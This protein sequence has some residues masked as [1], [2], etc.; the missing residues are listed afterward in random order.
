MTHDEDLEED[1]IL[2]D[3]VE[4]LDIN[5]EG[6]DTESY[7]ELDFEKVDL[8]NSQVDDFYEMREKPTEN[9]NLLD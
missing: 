6:A 7:D 5:E 8:D 3:V 2:F 1:P 4:S 9:G